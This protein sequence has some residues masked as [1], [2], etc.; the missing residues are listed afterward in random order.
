MRKHSKGGLAELVGR[1]I[2]EKDLKLRDVARKSDG[3][4]AQSYVSRIISGDVTNLS[5]EKL[6]ALSRGIEIDPYDLFS[7]ATGLPILTPS[8]KLKDKVDLG[9][10]EFVEIMRKVVG[11]TKLAEIVK[12]AVRLWPEE[13]TVVLRYV[14]QLNERKQKPKG[15][16]LPNDKAPI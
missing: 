11:N 9:A 1:V 5:T 10:V 7:A 6:M 4:I 16:K 13:H 8:R 15:K 2:R 12:E 3:Q 14:T